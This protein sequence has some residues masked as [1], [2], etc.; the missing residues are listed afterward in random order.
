MFLNV[1]EISVF[2]SID[3]F[4]IIEISAFDS[5]DG[6]NVI[7]ISVFDSILMLWIDTRDISFLLSLLFLE[8]LNMWVVAWL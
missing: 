4:N 8:F 1:I 3:V 7:E 6:L 2:D 5:I